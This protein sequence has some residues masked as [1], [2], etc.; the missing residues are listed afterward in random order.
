MRVLVVE[1]EWKISAY[2]KRGLDA[3]ADDCPINPFAL[4]GL[5]A[6]LRGLTRRR[7]NAPKSTVP[8]VADPTLDTVRRR[9]IRAGKTIDLTT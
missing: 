4:K 7:N 8:Q 5:L 2:V 6:R 3:G 9:V 1:D